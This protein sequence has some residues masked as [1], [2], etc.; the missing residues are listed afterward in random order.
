MIHR[1]VRVAQ[2]VQCMATDWTTGRY[3]FDP[4]RG[5]RFLP[6]T[7]VS[8]PALGPTQAPV[9]WIKGVLSPG[10][11]SGRGVMQTTHSYLVPRS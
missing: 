4:G 7:S 3:R 10:V 11:T 6:L 1:R 2:S 5:K 9:Q 8:R